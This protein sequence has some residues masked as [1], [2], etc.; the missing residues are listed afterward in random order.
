MLDVRGH[1]VRPDLQVAGRLAL[2]DLGIQRRPLAAG[3]A[4]LEAE[5]DLLAG[6]ATIARLAV[7]RHIPGV[8]LLVAELAG[9]G[10]QHLEVVVA[11]QPR[12]PIRSRRAHLVLGLRIP[13]LH[14]GERDRPVEQVRTRDVAVRAARLELVLLEAQR[15]ASP[16]HRRAADRLDDP[17]RQV[18]KIVRHAPG[19]RRGAHVLPGELGKA[20]PFVVDEIRDLMAS[21]GFQDHHLDAL[22]RKLVAERA[23]AGAGA[24]NAD[25]GVVVQIECRHR[26]LPYAC[27]SQSMSLK[28]RLM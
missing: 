11:R 8:H 15:S 21:A 14:L 26:R 10:F 9:A 17:R 27:G 4:A 22:L 19:T 2:R 23:A 24:D 16:V 20:R 3:L 28:P 13:R 6:A 1:R 5:A 7:D 18:G 25:H 12:D